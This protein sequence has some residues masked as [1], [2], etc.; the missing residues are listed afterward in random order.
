MPSVCPFDTF[1]LVKDGANIRPLDEH[2]ETE[3]PMLAMQFLVFNEK[4]DVPEIGY[5]TVAW[6]AAFV[7]GAAPDK[8]L[9]PRWEAT[10]V[11]HSSRSGSQ[12]LQVILAMKE[13]PP[14]ISSGWTDRWSCSF[15]IHS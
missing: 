1:I 5:Y 2:K 12:M 7:C 14:R 15:V 9:P 6:L 4:R 10:E 3:C 11:V 13:F 8:M